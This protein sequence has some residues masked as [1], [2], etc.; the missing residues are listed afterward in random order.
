[1]KAILV[2]DEMPSCCRDCDLC[3]LYHN[4]IL[5]ESEYIC[6][7]TKESVELDNDFKLNNCPLKPLPKGHGRL[8]DID[9]IITDAIS[10]GFYEWYDE[11]KYAPTIIE[12]DTG[13][14]E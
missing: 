2:L 6:F 7:V 11:M 13:D 10:K 14:T 12:A 9:K 1:M 5:D 3:T 8:K 4:A